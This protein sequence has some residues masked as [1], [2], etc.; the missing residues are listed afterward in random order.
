MYSRKLM[1]IITL[2]LSLLAGVVMDGN[3]ASGSRVGTTAAYF[4]EFGY[5]TIGNAMGEAGATNAQDLSALYWNPAAL[6]YLDRHEVQVNYLPWILD[7][8]S[9]YVG[10]GFVHPNMG[11]FAVSFFR[12]GY[13]EEE[14]TTTARQ[15]GTGEKYDGQDLSFSVSYGRK[16]AQWF[17]F[18]ATAKYINSRIWHESASAFAVDLG[19]I[20]NTWFFNWTNKPGD[21][22][23]IGMSISNYGTRLKYEG[24]DLKETID[25]DPNNNGNY[26]YIP[27]MLE[28]SEWELPLIARI[29][30]SINPL[31]T[32]KQ[33]ITLAA[34]FLHANNSE[35]Y[36]NVGGQYQITFP[37]FGKF[38]LRGGYKGLFLED[39]EFGATFGFGLQINYLGNKA[40]KIDYAYRDTG[41]L[42]TMHSYSLG[43][44]F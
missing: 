18:G 24:I 43:F 15:D 44:L 27:T 32:E 7:I 17:S 41:L 12:T 35:E 37:T 14:V 8:N 28:T 1:V 2:I 33:R 11:N 3:A 26:A 31:V 42:G 21:G 22:L 13:G 39:S 38:A 29:G 6:G 10:A 16:L 20:V 9:S 34:D 30:L 25:V 36:V 40:L 23:N 4:L 5:N 19:A